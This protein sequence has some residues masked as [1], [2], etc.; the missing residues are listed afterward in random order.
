MKILLQVFLVLFTNLT[1][2]ADVKL[3]DVPESVIRNLIQLINQLKSDPTSYEKVDQLLR[4]MMKTK[5]FE[6][7]EAKTDEK[8]NLQ[9]VARPARKISRIASRGN[10]AMTQD[11]IVKILGLVVNENFDR[12]QVLEG[13]QKLKNK[14]T[15][16]GFINTVITVD[17]K[18]EPENK[19]AI[20]LAIT[21]GPECFIKEFKFDV[22]NPFLATRL[23]SIAKKFIKARFSANV[24]SD[25]QAK[26]NEEFVADN[27][28]YLNASL[29]A[30]QIDFNASYSE[31]TISYTVTD[32]YKIEFLFK[33]N[34]SANMDENSLRRAIDPDSLA[35]LGYNITTEATS[36]VKDYYL[37]AGYAHVSVNPQVKQYEDPP[38]REIH[39]YIEE[40]PQVEI[41]KFLIQGQISRPPQYYSDFI[42]DHSSDLVRKGF[43]NEKDLDRGYK[44]LTT[45]LRNQ[46]YF[47]ARIQSA[48]VLEGPKR[49]WVDV[50]I[51]LYEGPLT[52]VND[53]NFSGNKSF[54]EV[55]L[56]NALTIKKAG[57]L[58]LNQ[59]EES[60]E[61][62]RQF[63]FSNGYLEMQI[64]GS[65]ETLVTYN[66]T[67]TLATINFKI[68]EGPR[69]TVNS[70][71]ID[72]N[73]QTKNSVILR[74][75]KFKPGEALT[76]SAIEASINN[77]QR[78]GLFSKI[79]IET[80][81]KGTNQGPRTVIVRLGEKNPGLFK[82]GVGITNENNLNARGYIGV[83]YRNLFGTARSVSLRLEQDKAVAP[84][85][86]KTLENGADWLNNKITA[87]YFEPHIQLP[88]DSVADGRVNLTRS[89]MITTY[90]TADIPK[91]GVRESNSV[92]FLLE[93]SFTPNVKFT[94]ALYG[95]SHDSKFYVYELPKPG[96][97]EDVARIG[98][99]VDFDYRDDTF[100][101]TKGHFIR[102]NFDYSAPWFGST[103]TI[104]FIRGATTLS[105]YQPI[106]S[107]WVW[108]NSVRGGYI[109][110]LSTYSYIN[111]SNNTLNGVPYAQ[112]FSLG[113]RS[114]IR[115]FDPTTESI[116]RLDELK[117]NLVALGATFASSKEFAI[118]DFK[119]QDETYFYL[120]K[121]EVR[122]PIYGSIGGA[123]FYDGGAVIIPGFRFEREYRHSAGV[124]LR[125]ITPVGPVNLELA[126]KIDP[127]ETSSYKESKYQFHFSI[128]SF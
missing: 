49:Q 56:S 68:L 95:F 96:T 123:V 81:E 42:T 85:A 113:T 44:N 72:G 114:T 117:T 88:F 79:E 41:R 45:E 102:L 19:I 61:I 14:Y 82:F 26:A 100:N 58:H 34:T 6:S 36:R 32:P 110:N 2:A 67:S 46:G 28:R 107:G 43:Y 119:L 94:W 63:Y 80:F 50:Q 104:E 124:G 47:R 121:S 60:I 57:P 20:E 106:K 53:I 10:T 12:K 54:T 125:F 98:P 91:T 30:P 21:E 105:H 111:S 112:L 65:T 93:K 37:N 18:I 69:I 25:F 62:L 5:N 70:I 4:A 71:I 118:T 86:G 15:D 66:K 89:Q 90:P 78:L 97:E 52:I 92:D 103:S 99:A 11:E 38:R 77:L 3:I 73:D 22:K 76:P 128:G 126:Y 39:F 109:R 8:G 83:S 75:L 29:S 64:L 101:P 23:R 51:S 31:V 48:S 27:N 35:Q 13:T 122:F 16:L 115:G 40:G 55:E 59:L 116:P 84:L 74:E 1:F 24:L 127:I 108:A 33:G 120:L 87:G 17:F 9:I 7:V